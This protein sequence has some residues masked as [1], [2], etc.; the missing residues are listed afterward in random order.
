MYVSKDPI[1]RAKVNTLV[2]K[3]VAQMLWLNKCLNAI[4]VTNI[5]RQHSLMKAVQKATIEFE[6]AEAEAMP[7]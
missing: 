7:S 5:G 1:T 2:N 4:D 3:M 6:K